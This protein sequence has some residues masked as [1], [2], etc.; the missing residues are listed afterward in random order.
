MALLINDRSACLL[1]LFPGE[2]TSSMATTW[3]RG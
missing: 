3:P 1:S 2:T